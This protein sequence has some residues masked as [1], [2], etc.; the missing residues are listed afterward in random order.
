MLPKL[1]KTKLK[2]TS[3]GWTAGAG[4]QMGGGGVRGGAAGGFREDEE[5]DGGKNEGE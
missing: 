1:L 3:Q 2:L 4:S 5:R